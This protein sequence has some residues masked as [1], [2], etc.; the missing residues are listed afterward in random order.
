MCAGVGDLAPVDTLDAGLT[1][2]TPFDLTLSFRLRK[3]HYATT[4]VNEMT[5]EKCIQ[6]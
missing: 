1:V 5:R 4:M 6:R 2:E 3:G